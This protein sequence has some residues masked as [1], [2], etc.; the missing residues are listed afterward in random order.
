[1]PGIRK[2][3]FFSIFQLKI[4]IFQSCFQNILNSFLVSISEDP[5]QPIKLDATNISSIADAPVI[6]DAPIKFLLHG[7]TGHVNYSPNMELRPGKDNIS[8][9]VLEELITIIKIIIIHNNK[10]LIQ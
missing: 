1:M 8:F 4:F 9:I 6:I 7:Y 10:L 3:A 2:A 5:G